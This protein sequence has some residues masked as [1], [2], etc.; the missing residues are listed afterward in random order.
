MFGLFLSKLFVSF[1]NFVVLGRATG[2]SIVD[3][4]FMID[5]TED[6]QSLPPLPHGWAMEVTPDGKT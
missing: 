4:G 5:P 1:F 2:F 3:D 6:T